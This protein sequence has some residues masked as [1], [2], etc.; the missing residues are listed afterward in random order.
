MKKYEKPTLV[1]VDFEAVD[2][3]TISFLDFLTI[4]GENIKDQAHGDI[5]SK[6]N[7]NIDFYG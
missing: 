4:W 1:K 2:V 3:I 5:E 7:S 6:S